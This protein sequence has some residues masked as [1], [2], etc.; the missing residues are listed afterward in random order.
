MTVIVMILLEDTFCIAFLV[1]EEV[2]PLQHQKPTTGICMGNPKVRAGLFRMLN[3][4]TR[5]LHILGQHDISE[6]GIA[7]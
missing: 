6:T 7:V 2:L 1:T 5:K 4:G 3:L